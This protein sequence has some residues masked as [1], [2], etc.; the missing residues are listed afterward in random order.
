MHQLA[1]LKVSDKVSTPMSP[2]VQRINSCGPFGPA[3]YLRPLI[4]TQNYNDLIIRIHT[5]LGYSVVTGNPTKYNDIIRLIKIFIFS[6]LSYVS[7]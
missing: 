2:L 4:S 6:Y 3:K 7:N 1:N 5:Y